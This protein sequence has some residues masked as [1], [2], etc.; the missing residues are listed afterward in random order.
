VQPAFEY[1]I[2]K[3]NDA[4]I[5]ETPYKHIM[6]SDIFP[7]EF[8]DMLLEHIPSVST[9]TSKPKYPGRQTMTLDDFDILDEKKKIFWEEMYTFLRSDDFANILLKKFNISKNG[10]SNLFLHK[11]L[12]NFEVKPHRDVFSKLVTYLFYLPKDSS[13]SQLGTQMLVPNDGYVFDK[14]DTKH[15][16]WENFTTVKTSEYKPNSFFAFAPCE[17][18]FHAVKVNFPENSTKE[19]DTI[20]GFVFNKDAKDYPAYLFGK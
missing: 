8:Y 17:N 11:D 10:I 13:L 6:I 7:D 16:D 19:R 15:Q 20:R 4:P 2:K 5:I 12:E 1:V 14:N 3:V 9:Y 18:S